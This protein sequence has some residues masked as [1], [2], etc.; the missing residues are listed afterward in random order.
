MDP[1]PLMGQ[2]SGGSVTEVT[3]MIMTPIHRNPW[4]VVPGGLRAGQ[5]SCCG[6]GGAGARGNACKWTRAVRSEVGFTTGAR[7]PVVRCRCCCCRCSEACGCWQEVV[8]SYITHGGVRVH[9][10]IHDSSVTSHNE[11]QR[12]RAE[13][14]ADVREARPVRAASGTEPTATLSSDDRRTDSSRKYAA[15]GQN[16]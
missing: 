6:A 9:S 13:V 8:V 3:A 12:V 5:A 7:A 15:V 16:K 10:S 4:A 14:T 11:P 2:W 1:Q